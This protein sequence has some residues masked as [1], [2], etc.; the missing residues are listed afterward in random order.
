MHHRRDSSRPNVETFTEMDVYSVSDGVDNDGS[1]HIYF[2]VVDDQV[3]GISVQP[4]IYFYPVSDRIC[5]GP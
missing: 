4:A 5:G 1:W 3:V 2:E